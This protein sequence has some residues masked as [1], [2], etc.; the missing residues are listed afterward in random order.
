M[1]GKVTRERY[2]ELVKLGRDWVETMSR[3]QWR[4]GDAA[5]EIEPLRSYGGVNPSGKDDLFT[6][7]ES[8]RMFAEDV[9]LAYATVRT[10]RWVASRWPGRCRRAGVS[11]TIHRI[12]ASIP[13]EAEQF[14]AVSNPPACPTGGPPRWT[15]DSAKR[16]VGWKVDSPES[17]QEKVEAIHDLATDDAVAAVVITDF[18]RRPDVATKAMADDTARHAVNEAQFDR[19]RQE[20]QFTHQEAAPQLQRMEHGAEFMDLVAACAQFVATAGR[21]VPNMKGEHYGE[22]E[23]DTVGRGLARVR[24]AADWIEGA[25]MRG[26]TGLDEQLAKLMKGE[27]E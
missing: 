4:L 13:D 9:G 10:Y 3:A 24:A 23:R 17:V 11:F 26:E 15:H 19:F 18:L 2:D 7:S 20:V 21:I 8:I 1:V 27:G 22:A 16:V 6:V 12:L 5:L 25:V 14:E